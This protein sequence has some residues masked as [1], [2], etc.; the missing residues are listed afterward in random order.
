VPLGCSGGLPFEVAEIGFGHKLRGMTSAY[1]NQTDEQIEQAF[2]EIA[3]KLFTAK[4]RCCQCRIMTI[5]NP[6]PTLFRSGSGD[7]PYSRGQ[8]DTALRATPQS[9]GVMIRVIDACEQPAR[10]GT[11]GFRS[12]R[13]RSLLTLRKFC[14]IR[15]KCL[16]RMVR[17]RGF[18]PL[19][20]FGH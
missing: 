17:G 5:S 20:P 1:T 19:R 12:H 4:T 14:R 3:Y 2:P 16:K 10:S 8:W 7:E 11:H 9:P 13:P 6:N 15:A 18:E